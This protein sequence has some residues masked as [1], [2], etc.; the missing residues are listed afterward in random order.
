MGRQVAVFFFLLFALAARAELYPGCWPVHALT[1]AQDRALANSLLREALDTEA[2][3]TIVGGIKPLSWGIGRKLLPA[4]RAEAELLVQRYKRIVRALHCADVEFFVAANHVRIEPYIVHHARFRAMLA[5]HEAFFKK[6]GITPTDPPY[7]VLAKL[8][9]ADP[10]ADAQATGYLLGFPEYAV[11]HFASTPLMTPRRFVDIPTHRR[12]RHTDRYEFVYAAPAH[13][14]PRRE[15]QE[16][17]ERCRPV[18]TAYEARRALQEEP[19][20]LLRTWMLEAPKLFGLEAG[21]CPVR[22]IFGQGFP[23]VPR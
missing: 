14:G 3:Y 9:G 12:S 4:D 2:L 21:A 18:F 7:E 13:P 5:K 15:D 11:D 6:L 19:A 10:V 23:Q 8:Q 1:D 22:M 17:A 16:L 20:V